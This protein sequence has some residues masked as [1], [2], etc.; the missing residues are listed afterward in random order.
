MV[1]LYLFLLGQPDARIDG[2]IYNAGSDNPTLLELADM[3]RNAV[4]GDFPI[5]VEPADNLP[6]YR[7]SSNRMRSELGFQPSHTIEEAVR[8]LAAAFRNGEITGS[9][10]DPRYFNNKMMRR[11]DLEQSTGGAAPGI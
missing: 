4:G 10:D 8:D 7:L 9:F 1:D 6:S 3:V 11:V 5:D 2:K